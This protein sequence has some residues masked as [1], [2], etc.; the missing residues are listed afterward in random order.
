M[1]STG[2]NSSSPIDG[3]YGSSTLDR[4]D[5]F[6]MEGN[7]T[8]KFI[9]G[10]GI[11]KF[12]F[13]TIKAANVANSK[14]SNRYELSKN[15]LIHMLCYLEGELQARD[16]VIAALR[17]ERVKQYIHSL[18]A[19]RTNLDDPQA[20]LFRDKAAISG[21]HISRQ[22]SATAIQ[23]DFEVRSVIEQQ[24]ESL[25]QVIT[26]Q[27]QT[28][29][30][31][32]AFLSDS[33]ENNQRMRQELEEE[34]RKHEHDTAQGDD[35]TYG[36]E[37]E[38]TKLKQELETERAARKKLEK[39]LKKAQELLEFERGRQKQIVLLLLAE[40]KKIIMKYIEERKRSEDLAQ[41][42]SEEKQ[43][44]DSIAEGLEEESK[45]SLRMEAEL[46]KQTL[47]IE[48]ERK[49][50]KINF[51]KEEKRMKDLEL[52]L[53]QL[54]NENETFRKQI[55]LRMGGTSPMIV[56]AAAGTLSNK[57]RGS[58]AATTGIPDDVATAAVAS[59]SIMNVAKI[60]QPTA[61][62]SSVPVSGPTTGI[63]RSISPGQCLRQQALGGSNDLILG[64]PA[65]IGHT[66][67]ATFNTTLGKTVVGPALPSTPTAETLTKLTH[68]PSGGPSG[69]VSTPNL[70]CSSPMTAGS[71]TGGVTSLTQ[72]SQ[73]AT[74]LRGTT[75]ATSPSPSA[76]LVGATL[77]PAGSTLI[78]PGA[79]VGRGM[80]PPIPPNKPTVPPKREPSISRISSTASGMTSSSN[81]SSS[82]LA[83]ATIPVVGSAVA[84]N[85]PSVGGTA[86]AV[87]PILTNSNSTVPSSVTNSTP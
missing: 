12:D 15:E 43:R 82:N 63:A 37:M 49:T 54:R 59:S 42:L 60:I 71:S 53:A 46:E 45:K 48:N 9:G 78:N 84:I 20:A 70:P 68:C 72:P 8:T 29:S 21:N 87:T 36:L 67:V 26:R 66:S 4:N 73:S 77:S 57:T 19:N 23:A 85:Q 83:G 51:A 75:N 58:A 14:R 16:V 10:T 5:P 1:T 27:R 31:M 74:F 80:P 35:I 17:N 62:V 39:D 65:G 86:A 3:I 81:S 44:S 76:S 22:S 34:K 64:S 7:G 40:R 25:H 69:L 32:I 24:I 18:R 11:N 52:E 13:H 28:Q 30:R 38:R 50:W 79:S 41:I 33:L 2:E 55:T 6:P 56:G 47:A 61:T